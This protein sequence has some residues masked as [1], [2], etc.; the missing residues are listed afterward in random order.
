MSQPSPLPPPPP[1]RQVRTCYPHQFL[2]P[3]ASTLTREAKRL[4]TLL[5]LTQDIHGSVNGVGTAGCAE[6]GA[7]T[8]MLDGISSVGCD[9]ANE[10][11]CLSEH[12][13]VNEI[14]GSA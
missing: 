1:A 13:R 9:Y 6:G 4:R 12:G 11:R 3:C 14:W 2:T 5:H 8:I 10:V 7:G